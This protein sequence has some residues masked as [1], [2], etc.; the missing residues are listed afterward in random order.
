MVSVGK[1][2]R[3]T[4][5]SE[6]YVKNGF[7][8]GCSGERGDLSRVADGFRCRRC[9]GTIQEVDLAEDLM[10]DGETYECVKELLLSGR[11][12]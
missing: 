4:L 12:S 3:Q 6:Q 11:H 2:Y 8:N 5:F 10:V 7:T 1:E 9:D